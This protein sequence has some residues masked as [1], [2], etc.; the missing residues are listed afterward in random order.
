MQ[1]NNED[2]HGLGFMEEDSN[3]NVCDDELNGALSKLELGDGATA[4]NGD[5]RCSRGSG[6]EIPP[7]VVPNTPVLSTP[8]RKSTSRS[9]TS[10][11]RSST[12]TSRSSTSTS[13]SHAQAI[14]S[15]PRLHDRITA[16]NTRF[17][18]AH[19][20]EVDR[21]ADARLTQVENFLAGRSDLCLYSSGRKTSS[22][23]DR[24]YQLNSGK[25]HFCKTHINQIDK[26]ELNKKY[27]NVTEY[28]LDALPYSR[29]GS[30]GF[31]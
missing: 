1:N 24:R 4:R 26:L 5:L 29:S 21:N 17:S 7:V 13:R 27:N 8:V 20:R 23:C 25:W 10:T 28:L 11:S 31:Q 30:R 9:S 22:S 14:L 6:V 12:S 16:L 3:V 18:Q 19:E 15:N 2:E